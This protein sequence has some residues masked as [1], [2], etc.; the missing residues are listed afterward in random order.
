MP[1]K[2]GPT[3]REEN[4]NCSEEGHQTAVDAAKLLRL[5]R[6]LRNKY[7][8]SQHKGEASF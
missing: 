3:F 8:N 2:Q 4:R 6:R 1:V 5:V 7:E